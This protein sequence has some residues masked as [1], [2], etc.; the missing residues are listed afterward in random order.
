MVQMERD[1]GVNKYKKYSKNAGA[2]YETLCPDEATCSKQCVVEDADKE[3]E[4]NC[5]VRV[6]GS[7]LALRFVTEGP[8]TT[9]VMSRLYVLQDENPYKIFHLKNREFTFN[10]DEEEAPESR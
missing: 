5:G 4:G 1:D 10:V 9:N 7:E 3:Y 6:K 2:K 8:Y